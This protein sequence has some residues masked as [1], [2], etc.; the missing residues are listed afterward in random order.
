MNKRLPYRRTN[1]LKCTIMTLVDCT[2]IGRTVVY[3]VCQRLIDRAVP[4]ASPILWAQT[5][6]LQH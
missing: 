6:A 3:N 4:C 2:H 5:T 1:L